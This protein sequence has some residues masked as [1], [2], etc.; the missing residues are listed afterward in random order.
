MKDFFKPVIQFVLILFCSFLIMLGTIVIVNKIREPMV[1]VKTEIKYVGLQ[2][3]CRD[4]IKEQK[5][6]PCKLSILVRKD[7]M[8]GFVDKNGISL[9]EEYLLDG[10]FCE[11]LNWKSQ[12]TYGFKNGEVFV[13]MYKLP[14][15]T[16]DNFY[17]HGKRYKTIWPVEKI[18]LKK[19]AEKKE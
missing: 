2:E 9:F 15:T 18:N 12:T 8:E 14:W 16:S 6:P 13:E 7:D 17:D 11:T 5:K 19:W 4:K 1:I 10:E 3:I